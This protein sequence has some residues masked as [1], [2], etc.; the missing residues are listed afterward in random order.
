MRNGKMLGMSKIIQQLETTAEF[1]SNLVANICLLLAMQTLSGFTLKRPSFF[2]LNWNKF[3]VKSFLIENLCPTFL[4]KKFIILFYKGNFIAMQPLKN[5]VGE[6]L[7]WEYRKK[8]F[9]NDVGCKTRISF[10]LGQTP[11][12]TFTYK[13]QRE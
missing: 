2:S 7:F 9:Y 1:E 8:S 13:V 11:P 4:Q 5:Y 6:Y 10:Q 12:G 3:F